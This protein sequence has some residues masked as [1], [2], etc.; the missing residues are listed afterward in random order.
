MLGDATRFDPSKQLPAAGRPV[1]LQGR[2]HSLI[3]APVERSPA[4]GL[5]RLLGGVCVCVCACV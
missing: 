2:P 3:L 4:R 1:L 5:N